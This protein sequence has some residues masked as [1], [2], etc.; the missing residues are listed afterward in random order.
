MATTRPNRAQPGSLVQMSGI[1][2]V[3]GKTDLIPSPG[4]PYSDGYVL[5]IHQVAGLEPDASMPV[6]DHH[7]AFDIQPHWGDPR[8]PGISSTGIAFVKARAT[9]AGD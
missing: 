8:I 2:F 6:L 1:V 7:P 3:V 5:H 9:P 4:P